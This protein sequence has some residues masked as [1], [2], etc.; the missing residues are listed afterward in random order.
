MG[1]TKS[2]I[3]SVL[4]GAGL[5]ALGGLATYLAQQA[6]TLPPEYSVL[7]GAALSIAAN[8]VRK[9]LATES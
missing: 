1:W 2:K 9:Y 7:V 8:A 4:K 6:A 3:V 5:A